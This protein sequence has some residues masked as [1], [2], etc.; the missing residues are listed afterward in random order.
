M[1]GSMI[2]TGGAPLVK[3]RMKDVGALLRADPQLRSYHTKRGYES[4]LRRFLAWR[5]GDDRATK[6]QVEAYASYLLEQGNSPASVNRSL[7]A[8]RWLARKMA[9][10]AF[11]DE[12]MAPEE[13]EFWAVHGERV[14]RKVK[15]VRSKRGKKGRE[16][17]VA[18]VRALLEACVI[19][20]SPSGIRDAAMIAVAW[21]VG[22]RRSE[23][24]WSTEKRTKHGKRRARGLRLQDYSPGDDGGGE[25]A[26]RDG[27]G[28]KDRMV[29]IHNGATA[30]LDDWLA[31]R[32]EDPGPMFYAIRKDGALLLGQGLTGQALAYI[33]EKR[34][35]QAAIKPLTW[36]DFRR[37][38]ATE[39]LRAG[40][41]ITVV[42]RGLGHEQITTT[43]GYDRSGDEEVR[44][45]VMNRV[46]PYVRRAA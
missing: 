43:A 36:H 20:D 19:D 16:I 31:I 21:Q 1:S 42:A 9:D 39:E 34:A 45:L 12:S 18:E 11:E 44:Q 28:D 22:P 15:N 10:L 35:R 4:D 40:T 5:N 17:S 25:L 26:I 33:L 13:R 8:I 46:I 7:A 37:T 29:P 27:K 23:I 3:Q 2:V 32:G 30:Y 24:G 6:L 41:P 14:A 38:F